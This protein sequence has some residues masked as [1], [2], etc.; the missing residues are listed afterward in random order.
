M[1]GFTTF[2][3]FSHVGWA[4]GVKARAATLRGEVE[5]VLAD[6]NMDKV[7]I[8]GHSMGGLDARHMLYDGR[9]DQ[10]ESKIASVTTIGTPHW[11]SSFA[12]Y[13]LERGEAGEWQQTN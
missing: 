2:A 3:I 13:V 6:S 1:T 10:F 7:H 9:Q 8:I 5:R 4:E 12:D 11:G